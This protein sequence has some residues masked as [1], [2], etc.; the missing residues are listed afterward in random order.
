MATATVF[1]WMAGFD[2]AAAPTTDVVESMSITTEASKHLLA[3][4]DGCSWK[5]IAQ[6]R[7]S[8][9]VAEKDGIVFCGS[10]G[11]VCDKAGLVAL[12]V[13]CKEV[14]SIVTLS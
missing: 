13:F 4:R 14:P 3:A 10:F 5:C 1:W 2:M 8:S 12:W 9:R 6:T 7:R 11:E